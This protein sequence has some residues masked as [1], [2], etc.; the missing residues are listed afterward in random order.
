MTNK[1]MPTPD[2]G[3]SDPTG[4]ELNFVGKT[5]WVIVLLLGSCLVVS[6]LFKCL[7]E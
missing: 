4:F 5:L 7:M 2:L 3:L 6:P 1:I